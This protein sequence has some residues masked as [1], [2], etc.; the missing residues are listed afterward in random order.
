M[1]ESKKILVAGGDLRQIYLARALAPV[2]PI[3]TVGF[4]RCT[5]PPEIIADN[6][7]DI[8]FRLL[9]GLFALEDRPDVVVLP[10]PASSDGVLVHTPFCRQSLPLDQLAAVAAENAVVL[11]GRLSPAVRAIFESRGLTTVDYFQ[12][13][14]LSILNSVPTAEG[15]LQIAMEELPVTIFGLNVL[16]TGMGRIS[17][18]LVRLFTALGAKVTVA[19][20]KCGDLAWAEV[21]GCQSVHISRMED[22]LPRCDLVLNTVPAILLDEKHLK[23]LR[24]A[25]LVIDLASKPGGVDFD[26]AAR[27]G[28]KTIW[29][30]SLPGKAAPVTAGEMIAR[31]ICNILE[32]RSAQ[33]NSQKPRASSPGKGEIS[34]A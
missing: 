33:E 7:T 11:G 34:D 30:L 29:A 27:L 3:C 24:P 16:I 21:M 2:Y 18:V 14:E 28:I 9:D 15:A 12:R 10:L 1:N 17:R 25:C 4:D 26:T 20:R 6:H 22:A 32:E 23:K 5:V 13:E 31:T 19:A 8:H